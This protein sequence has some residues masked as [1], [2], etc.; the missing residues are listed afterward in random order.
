MLWHYNGR[1]NSH[2]RWKQT[3]F[4]VC[5]HLWCELTSIMNV[6]EW[7]VSWNSCKPLWWQAAKRL[8][9][10]PHPCQ[11]HQLQLLTS[12]FSGMHTDQFFSLRASCQALPFKENRGS[13]GKLEK[14]PSLIHKKQ[15]FYSYYIFQFSLIWWHFSM[16]ALMWPWLSA[17]YF[18][19]LYQLSVSMSFGTK[20]HYKSVI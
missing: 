11:F 19:F 17:G 5:F 16:Q 15:Q 12:S 7:Q 4:R 1:V 13:S 3:R 8:S 6:T 2:Q 10:S 14:S 9:A 18:S 20:H